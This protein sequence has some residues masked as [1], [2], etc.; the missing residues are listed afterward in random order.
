MLRT[1]FATEVERCIA[2][3]GACTAMDGAT[4]LDRDL[5][6]LAFGV[7]LSVAREI[8][9]AEAVDVEG[10]RLRSFDLASRGA[11]HKAA[12]TYAQQF[13]GSVV[14][15]ASQDGPVACLFRDPNSPVVVLWRFGHFASPEVVSI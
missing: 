6:L 10:S 15:V 5:R 13:P 9:V 2:D 4:L 1:A 8:G 11:R 3:Y 12:A 7:V 14:F